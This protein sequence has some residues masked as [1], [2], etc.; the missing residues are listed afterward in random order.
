MGGEKILTRAPQENSGAEVLV[1]GN[2]FLSLPA[3]FQQ[4]LVES[5]NFLSE[6][7]RGLL[8]FRPE[9]GKYFLVP[10]CRQQDRVLQPKKWTWKQL[11][12]WV[13]VVEIS[14]PG[15]KMEITYLFPPE[16]RG[17]VI[18]IGY[19]NEG[20]FAQEISL[21]LKGNWVS[22]NQTI[23]RSRKISGE[24]KLVQDNW[25]QTLNLEFSSGLSLGALAIR[26]GEGGDKAQVAGGEKTR[27]LQEGEG[28]TAGREKIEFVLEQEYSLNPGEEVIWPVYI[29]G[30]ADPDAAATTCVH[31]H[32]QGWEE[33]LSKSRSWLQEKKVQTR[34]PTLEKKLNY[35]LFFNYFFSQG[36]SIEKGDLHLLTSRSPRYYVSG[37]YWP[38]DS[39]LWSLPGIMEID[40]DRAKELY[41]VAVNRHWNEGG[42]HSQYITG[43]ELYPGFEVDQLCAYFI[44][45]ERF[46]NLPG[47]KLLVE[48]M[49]INRMAKDFFRWLYAWK[50]EEEFLFATFLDPADDPPT[51]PYVTYNQVLIWRVLGF[52]KE[53]ARADLLGL[54]A[55]W[56]KRLRDGIENSIHQHAVVKSDGDKEILAGTFDAR[57]NYELYEN[58]PGAL[59]LLPY[60]G[61]L[62]ADDP[63]YKNTMEWVHS[64]Q[65]Q[66]YL[67]KGKFPG[68]AS[69]HADGAWVLAVVSE[70]LSG[71]RPGENREWIKNAPLDGGLACETVDP[72]TGKAKTGLA[73]S[74]CSGFL[75]YSLAVDRRRQGNEPG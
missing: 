22:C 59:S 43:G 42:T 55:S 72:E 61:F 44:A 15:G 25:T 56:L 2:E 47:G 41:R 7:A 75:G 39:L 74:T 49:P 17:G 51:Y 24:K 63:I 70:L 64:S 32:R 6:K 57:G 23:Y 33:M 5:I 12:Y 34:P 62:A 30:G 60:W 52:F 67:G 50:H 45:M 38:R 10:F 69:A 31:L 8:E 13:P 29:A 27:L 71:Y 1:T 14:C 18:I 20:L 48:G 58:P 36:R 26:G 16:E 11:D 73:F 35:N 65:N 3:L 68:I 54:P 4:G 28:I 9:A 19:K 53:L 66:Y 21:G 40:P 37:A 46:W